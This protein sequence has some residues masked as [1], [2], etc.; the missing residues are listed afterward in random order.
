MNIEA[1]NIAVS[2]GGTP[3]LADVSLTLRP[4]ELVGLIGPNGAGK[5][6]LLRV[7][8]GL[9]PPNWGSLL[10][11]GADHTALSRSALA[12]RL[13]F[14]AQGGDVHWQMRVDRVVALGRLPHRRPFAGSSAA[15]VSAINRAMEATGIAH[16]ALRNT[17]T[18]SGGE[19]MR[20]LLARALAVEADMLLA[21][22]PVAALDPLHQL[23]IMQL[24][25]R[26]ARAGTGVVVVL[27]DLALAT[28]FCDRL[29]VLSGGGIL[30]DGPPASLIDDILAQ[31]Y[32]ITTLRGERDGQA[33]VL[34]WSVADGTTQTP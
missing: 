30:L 25:Q 17:A 22:E 29:V 15:D 7:L 9:M 32:G 11:D 18:L 33:Y 1:R 21:D 27:H 28:R 23:L 6:T 16:L 8:A 26:E 10:Y 31:A 14:L 19:K 3:I 4:G 5:T 12:R 24:L 20:V 34:P 2:A 13:A